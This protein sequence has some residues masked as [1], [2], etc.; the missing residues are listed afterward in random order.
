MSSQDVY[1][2][3]YW[4]VT[5][6]QARL[7]Y[8]LPATYEKLREVKQRA[9]DSGQLSLKKVNW[10]KLHVLGLLE[11]DRNRRDWVFV[12]QGPLWQEFWERLGLD[13]DTCE[14]D[15]EGVAAVDAIFEKADSTTIP[16]KNGIAV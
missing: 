7:L 1:G 8:F 15:S 5:I 3:K 6:Y 13:P 4:A 16:L 9:E 2:Q 14:K 12:R 11:V 10:E